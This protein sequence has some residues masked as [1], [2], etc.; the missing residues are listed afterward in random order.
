VVT[1]CLHAPKGKI[2]PEDMLMSVG[3][4]IGYAGD[5]TPDQAWEILKRDSHAQLVD[6]RTAPEWAFV[7][8]PDVAALGRELHKVEWQI[9]PQMAVN[10]DFVARVEER[11]RTSGAERATPVLFLCRS[12]GRSRA[13]AIALASAGYTQALNV[14]GGFE[15]DVDAAGHRGT[16]GGWKAAGLPWRQ[17]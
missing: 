12:G 9:F 10:V 14:A 13:A 8:L 11:L 6:V 17:S 5:I 3:N 16:I 2:L 7:G 1:A 15:G 4:M